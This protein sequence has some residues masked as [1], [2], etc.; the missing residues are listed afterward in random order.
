MPINMDRSGVVN[1]PE[2]YYTHNRDFEL[3]DDHSRIRKASRGAG[4]SARGRLALRALRGTGHVRMT[5]NE[6]IALTR[7][8]PRPRKRRK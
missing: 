4:E 5:T 6:I 1:E 7:G 3:A 2:G 8:E